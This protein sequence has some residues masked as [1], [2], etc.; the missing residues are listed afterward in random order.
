MD[1]A[2]VTERREAPAHFHYEVQD[3]S[4]ANVRSLRQQLSGCHWGFATQILDIL[5]WVCPTERQYDLARKR[6]ING[7]ERAMAQI[8]T[9][10]FAPAQESG[11]DST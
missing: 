8:V 9:Q 10:A 5:D 3:A 6:A 1:K 7:Q 4:P 2:T 11:H